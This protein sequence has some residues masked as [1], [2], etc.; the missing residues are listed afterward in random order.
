MCPPGH[1]GLADRFS[2]D[3]GKYPHNSLHITIFITLPSLVGE[4]RSRTVT[5]YTEKAHF[6]SADAHGNSLN[7]APAIQVANNWANSAIHRW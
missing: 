5:L 2:S 3:T 1:I 6:L 7:V 4:D